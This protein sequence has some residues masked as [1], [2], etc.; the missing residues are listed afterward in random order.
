MRLYRPVV[1]SGRTL[2]Y[3]EQHGCDLEFWDAADTRAGGVA[4]IDETPYG[5]WLPSLE[6][7]GSIRIGERDY[8]VAEAFLHDLPEA[9]RFPV[10]AVFTWVDDADPA[11]QRR[12]AAVRAELFGGTS[13]EL[14][15]TA[16]DD[17]D[18]RY[19][20]HDELRYSL[21]S[22]AM[23]A[24][25]IRR[26]FLV[27]A[28]QVP[29]WLDTE[30]PGL[31]V[32]PHR[33]LLP[34]G[35]VFNSCAIE[36]GLH[37]IPGL[38]E[39]FLYFNDDMFLGRPVRPEDF[40]LGNGLPKV[41]RDTRIVPPST[42]TTDPDV[43]VAGQQNTSA[44][45]EA[46]HGRI[47]TRVLAHVPYP[48]RRSLLEDAE[49]RWPVE[50]AATGRSAFRAAD[51]VAPVTLAL[52]HAQLG[53]R[54]VDGRL[55]HEYRAVD[56]VEDRERLARLLAERDVDAFCLADGTGDGTPAEEQGRAL[57]AF[58]AAYFPVPGPF[59]LPGSAPGAEGQHPGGHPGGG[60]TVVEGAEPGPEPAIGIP[61]PRRVEVP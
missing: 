60:R 44:L 7:A 9:V 56:C 55:V 29:S 12:R 33:D 35:P 59:E 40:F 4:S 52:F 50:L 5:W 47:Y 45:L 28:D 21:R 25:W 18:H 16:H 53:G 38:A 20:N 58:L 14:V 32:V 31:T 54:A 36:T 11:W 17:G 26:I 30:V 3:G 2:H 22:L 42:G 34:G 24:P 46:E 48:L 19:R 23:Y 49:R 39:H 10:D 61:V 57:S 41:F 6:A 13:P 27:T 37:R 8:P 1:T 43:Y 51:D 15:D